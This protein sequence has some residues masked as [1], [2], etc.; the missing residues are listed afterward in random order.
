MKT[1]MKVFL[2]LFFVIILF[3]LVNSAI[4]IKTACINGK[5]FDIETADSNEKINKGLSKREFLPEDSGMLF[6]FEKEIIPKFWMK[7][8]NFP[9]DIIWINKEMEILGIEENLQPCRESFC[10]TYSPKKE[11][12]YVLEIN[13]GISETAEFKEGHKIIFRRF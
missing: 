3:L 12:K 1:T 5:C 9:L 6:I 7:D 13:A 10:Q 11:I 8:M 2:V 4:E